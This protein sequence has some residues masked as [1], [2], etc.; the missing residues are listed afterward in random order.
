MTV[1]KK[2]KKEF[3]YALLLFLCLCACMC[4][5]VRACV[6]VC[7]RVCVSLFFWFYCVMII[8]LCFPGYNNLLCVRV[9]LVVSSVEL[10]SGKI[11]CKCGFVIKYIGF[12]IYG[13]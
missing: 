4:A 5:C 1:L 8:F 11:L 13:N 10:S 9:Y 7:V 3:Y 2:K 6:C 12:S